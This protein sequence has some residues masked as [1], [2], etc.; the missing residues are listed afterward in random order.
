MTIS[1]VQKVTISLPKALL[2]FADNRA[3]QTQ[4]SR[5]QIISEALAAIKTQ[6]EERLAVEGYQFYAQEAAEFA[7][8]SADSV[9]NAWKATEGKDNAS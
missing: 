3:T 5:S 7:A 2:D 8:A 9:S 4:K 1:S 6:E